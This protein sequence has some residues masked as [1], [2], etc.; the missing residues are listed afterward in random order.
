MADYTDA[1]LVKQYVKDSGFSAGTVNWERRMVDVWP[2]VLEEAAKAGRLRAL[3][4]VIHRDT[5]TAERKQLLDRLLAAKPDPAP[6]DPYRAGLLAAKRSFIDR[7]DLRDYLRDLA[8]GD[9]SRVLVVNGPKNSGKSHSWFLINYVGEHVGV[10][11]RRL[12]D[13]STYSGKV[14]AGAVVVA[15]AIAAL[16]GWKAPPV[17]DTTNSEDNAV[18]VLT[19]WFVGNAAEE[20]KLWWLVFDGLDAPLVGDGARR[21]VANIAAASALEQAGPLRVVLLEFK[22]D[23]NTKAEHST[24]RETLAAVGTAEIKLFFEAVA[25]QAGALLDDGAIEA[26]VTQLLG[27]PPHP[28]QVSLLDIGPAAGQL[29]SALFGDG[30]GG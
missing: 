25:D 1:P 10:A 17:V 11:R 21:M 2:Q 28:E 16:L 9:G 7:V 22:T 29:A 6:T 26:L 12:I 20:L 14:P 18:F 8:R 4:K 3:V 30:A 27:P 23:L 19:S 13:L 24:L 15:D 5:G